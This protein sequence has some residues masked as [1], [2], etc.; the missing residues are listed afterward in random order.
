MG[1][2]RGQETEG[3]KK[4]GKDREERHRRKDIK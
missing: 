1:R 4:R 3:K 2:D